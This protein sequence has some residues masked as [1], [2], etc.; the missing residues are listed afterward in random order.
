MAAG[1]GGWGQEAGGRG[2]QMTAGGD[3][4]GRRDD[5]G[6]MRV[7]LKETLQ[8][9]PEAAWRA[10][11][12]PAVLREISGPLIEIDSLAAGGFPTIWEPGGHP[13]ALYLGGV[14]PLGEQAIELSFRRVPAE[15]LVRM[16]RDN[17]RGIS[18]MLSLITR[19]DHR[20]AISP[21][22][23]GHESTLYRDQLIYEAGPATLPL[24]PVLW[25]MWQWRARQLK[26]MAPTWQFDLGA[27][28]ES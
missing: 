17:G 28:R 26:R 4:P 23:D 21:G 24:W 8:C 19:W 5:T 16:L 3:K 11:R 12:S 2:R 22:L 1:G 6:C 7:L 18:S 15:P 10:I 20:I 25:S 14:V 13:V 9:R 27:D